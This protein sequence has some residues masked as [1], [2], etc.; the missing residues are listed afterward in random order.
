MEPVSLEFYKFV[1]DCVPVGVLTVDSHLRITGLNPWA[2][3]ITG[4]SKSEA[5]N[6]YCGD[7]LHGGMCDLGCPLRTVLRREAPIIA[8]ETVIRNKS[9]GAVPVRMHTAGLFDDKGQLI[10]GVEVFQDVSRLKSLQRE[11]DN[12]ISMIAHDMK[13]PIVAI[14]GFAHRLLKRNPDDSKDRQYLSVIEKE[15]ER[16][17]SMIQDFLEFSRLEAGRL[18]LNLSAAS[19]DKELYELHETYQPAAAEKGLTLELRSDEPLPVIE[20]DSR[21][22]R[23]VFTNL[24]DNALKF[25]K[26]TGTITISTGQTEDHVYVEVKDQ[27]IGIDPADLPYIFETFHRAQGEGRK[28]GGFGLGLAAVKTIV[29]KHGGSLQAHSEPG[30]GSTFVVRLPKMRNRVS[31]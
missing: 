27:G 14:H 24:L 19:L 16:L 23:R 9:G 13:S 10:G 15:S 8:L 17:E 12:F 3:K 25:S 11:R 7:I 2:E 26:E 29:E 4:F 20:A 30:K 1:I 5:V 21:Q 22:L 31:N 18:P 28:R 6:R